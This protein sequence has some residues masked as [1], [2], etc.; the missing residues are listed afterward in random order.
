[1]PIVNGVVGVSDFTQEK[2]NIFSGLMTMHVAIVK[3]ILSRWRKISPFY[4]Y[5]DMTAGPGVY[6][7]EDGRAIVGSPVIA[8]MALTDAN[9]KYR[10]YLVERDSSVFD[11]LK[12]WF[13]EEAIPRAS[14]QYLCFGDAEELVPAIRFADQYKHYG[15][16]Y[17][18]T[19]AQ[20]PPFE[21]FRRLG[22]SRQYD[23]MDFIMT[24]AAASHKRQ[25][26]SSLCKTEERLPEL[27]GRINKK[28]WLI[29]EPY[30]KHQ[31]TFLIGTNWA[32]FPR[33]NKR[34]F[35]G[36]TNKRGNEIYRKIWLTNA[37]M[38]ELTM[39]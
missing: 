30:G 10:M 11:T 9:V 19:T 20:I 1:M 33:W 12:S 2:Q 13:S 14:E 5:V 25:I 6:K 26:K 28:F 39:F 31:W 4:Y 22:Q 16:V 21:T 8:R 27:L 23:N 38:E 18:D 36:I 7:D 17:A 37:E 24:Y 3:G 34:G 15:L 35:Y 32:D 29:R